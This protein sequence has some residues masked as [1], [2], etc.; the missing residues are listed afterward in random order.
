MVTP[1]SLSLAV[2][3]SSMLASASAHAQVMQPNG[4]VVPI[5]SGRVETQLHELFADRGESIDFVA[6]ASATPNTFSPLCE[7]TASFVLNEARFQY[8]VGWYNVVPGA[9][10][11][12]TAAEI[13]EVIPAGAPLGTTIS[14]TSIR[15][16]PRYLGGLVGF[17]LMRSPA[18]FTEAQ[19][20][21]VCS[22]GPCA[23][24]PGPWILSLSYRST[25]S[26]DGW[27]IAFE[28]GNTSSSGWSNDGDYNDDVFFFTGLSCAG[29]GEACEVPEAMGACAVGLT[30]C[31]PGGGLSCRE[32][33][34]PADET[35]DAIDND[36]DGAVDEG[37]A[38]CGAAEACDRG[39]CV[40]SCFE[41]GC[42]EG[43]SC[44]DGLCVETACVDV[45]CGPG[46]RCL[47]GAC[48]GAC[49]GVVCPGEQ[50][51]R[52]GVCVDA[53]AGVTCEDGRVCEAGVC[54][55]TCECRPCGAGSEC[56]GAGTC[57][58]AGCADVTCDAPDICRDGACVD[59]CEGAVC[60]SGQICRAGGCV[61][62]SAPGDGGE[63]DS[64]SGSGS[65][66]DGG[67]SGEVTSGC[68]CR[69]VGRGGSPLAILFAALALA[70]WRRRR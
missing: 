16:D 67:G 51:C 68:G 29:A 13:Y 30:E 2:L 1:R 64:G 5:D 3:V 19:W 31:E 50:V 40:A 48:V 4:M 27:Y 57:V 35:C 26:P 54:V 69:V 58:S 66:A 62:P 11:A 6:D 43:Q 59:P 61:D 52:A 25:V 20:N 47:D 41:G 33:T 15:D 63:L 24:S 53:C 39:V 7:F 49:E 37:E 23:G 14:G 32:V 60:P 56:G 12:P 36:C 9:T 34:S 55:Q 22:S 70:L 21:T 8:G 65:G 44:A 38:L 28:D 42:G 45:E 10:T 17:A 18:H 46:E